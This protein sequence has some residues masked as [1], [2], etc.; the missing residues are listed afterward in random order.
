MHTFKPARAAVA[1]AYSVRRQRP[2]AR[3]TCTPARWKRPPQVLVMWV[4]QGRSTAHNARI[5][6]APGDRGTLAI[7][8][9]FT[10]K[11]ASSVSRRQ[12]QTHVSNLQRAESSQTMRA[13]DAT[14]ANDVAG[15][16]TSCTGQACTFSA[17]ETQMKVACLR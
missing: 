17:F 12:D 5:A 1:M 15:A 16:I 10:H 7:A 2:A 14:G 13:A 3:A 8:R 6:P 9:L 4:K 11:Q